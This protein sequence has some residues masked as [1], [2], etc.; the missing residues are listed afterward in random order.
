MA[1]K[2]TYKPKPYVA[3]AVEAEP[4]QEATEFESPVETELVVK[5]VEAKPTHHILTEGQNIQT[6]AAMYLPEGMTRNE[7]AKFLFKLN[8][9]VTWGQVVRLG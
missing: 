5:T 1:T 2:K 6:V 4:V 3:P 7:Y 8:G 9:H